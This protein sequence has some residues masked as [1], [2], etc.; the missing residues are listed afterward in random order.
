MIRKLTVI[1]DQTGQV[2]GTQLGHG[3]ADARGVTTSLVAGP[4]Q[5][6]RKIEFDVPKLASR[7]D[8]ERFHRTLTERIAKSER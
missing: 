3:A 8:I 6:A 7:Q 1:T 4:G 5:K 2:I